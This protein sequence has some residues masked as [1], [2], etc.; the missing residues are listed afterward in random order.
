[1]RTNQYHSLHIPPFV[2]KNVFRPAAAVFIIILLPVIAC[3]AEITL[4][5][6][7]NTEDDL[8]GYI[9]YYGT[10]SRNYSN[11]IDVGDTTL[12]TI[13]GFQ[14]GVTYYLA[15]K[16]YDYEDN[17]SGFS[18]ELVH[19]I[20][21][22]SSQNRNP[23]TPSTPSGL[24][25]GFHQTSYSFST[26]AVD[27]DEDPLEYNFDWGDGAISGWGSTPRS[28]SWSSS[29][30]FC[31]RAQARDSYGAFSEWSNCHTINITENTHTIAASANTHGSITPSGSI[32]VTDGSTQTFTI[33]PDQDHQI[34]DVQV[35]GA[36]LGAVNSYT[37]NNITRDHAIIASFVHV[38][39]V[40]AVDDS[41]ED[42]VPDDQ[43]AFPLDP[44]ETLDSDRDGVG[45][46]ADDDDDNDGM[47]DAW[48]T[49]YGLNPLKDDASE[50]PD[51]DN[52]SNLNEY[53]LGSKP[54]FFEDN[55]D[56]DPPMLITPSAH[57]TV[58]ATPVLQ[59]DA[60]YDPDHGDLHAES[61]WRISQ[62]RR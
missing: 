48:E 44:S 55:S 18:A 11:S 16:A 33:S 39:P 19:T 7:A 3:G 51:G 56:P 9:I 59:T 41:D 43:D 1:M 37:F 28:H 35:D 32:L 8:K 15:A 61:Q 5:W 25:S 57:E 23:D 45:N 20:A 42:G 4:A 60:F 31:V 29:G 47:P 46:N 27:P 13:S 6:D 21:D 53:H 14:E 54:N 49:L 58:N 52:V 40:P 2:I 38:D 12:Y 24:S 30:S 34:L 10:A 50:D 36:S 26:S 62:S 22:Q 17:Q